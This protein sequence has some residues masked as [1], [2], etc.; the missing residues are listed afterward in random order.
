M[1]KEKL[2]I[3]RTDAN[4]LFSNLRGEVGEIITTWVLW[5]H[6]LGACRQRRTD[7][8]QRDMQDRELQLLELLCDKLGDEATARLSE[9]GERKVGQLTFHFAIEKLGEFA[10]ECRAFEKFVIKSGIRKKRNESISH[11]QIPEQW[12]EHRD[13]RVPYRATL[14]AIA[15][16]VRLMKKIDREA[17]G[18]A[19]PFLWKE[20][21]FRRYSYMSPPRVGYLLLPYLALSPGERIRIA[22]AEIAEGRD[23]WTE[24]S[25]IIDGQ[26]GT[27]LACKPWGILHLGDRLLALER[28]PLND[29]TSISFGEDTQT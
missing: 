27:V 4:N 21:R 23:V 3:A 25:T 29:L 16:A 11:K 28:Y 17:L 6:F 7:D 2:K 19:A 18:P 5:R 1:S 15:M 8:I 24:V 14:K 12:H 13:I 10:A 9:L 26:P 22:M 20:A